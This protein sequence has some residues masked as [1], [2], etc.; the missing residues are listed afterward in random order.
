MLS[1]FLLRPRHGMTSAWPAATCCKWMKYPTLQ[2]QSR[3]GAHPFEPEPCP[4][5]LHPAAADLPPTKYQQHHGLDLLRCRALEPPWIACTAP[6]HVQPRVAV[7]DLQVQGDG[8]RTV[9]EADDDRRCVRGDT[10]GF[11]RS[12]ASHFYY[13]SLLVGCSMI[14]SRP[15]LTSSDTY[16]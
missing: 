11:A 9:P 8:Q 6:L 5:L 14:L 1:R 4:Y 10:G 3:T 15:A 13:F 7:L 16:Y 12:P 2:C